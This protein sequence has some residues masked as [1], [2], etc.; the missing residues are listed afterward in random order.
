MQLRKKKV[1]DENKKVLIQFVKRK[2]NGRMKIGSHDEAQKKEW[3]L[4]SLNA[5]KESYDKNRK[6]ITKL[7]KRK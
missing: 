4:K 2:G 6:V 1:Q 7:I 3:K 5:Y